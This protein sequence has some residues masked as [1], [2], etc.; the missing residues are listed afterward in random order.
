MG[1]IELLG[2]TG[3]RDVDSVRDLRRQVVKSE[4]GD[5]ADDALRDPGGNRDEVR[6]RESRERRQS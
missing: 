4:C 2:A 5:E 3:D 1:V 6:G